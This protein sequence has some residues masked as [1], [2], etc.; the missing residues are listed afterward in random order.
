MDIGLILYQPLQHNKITLIS[1]LHS[2]EQMNE[3]VDRT[4]KCTF[5]E[6]KEASGSVG[7]LLPTKVKIKAQ[8]C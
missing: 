8:E 4:Q 6:G 1:L 5:Q 7:I 2:H 3:G